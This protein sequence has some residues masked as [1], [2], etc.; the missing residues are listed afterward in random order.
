MDLRLVHT[1]VGLTLRSFGI[2]ILHHGQ[3]RRHILFLIH[4]SI[5]L[6]NVPGLVRSA[7]ADVA[8]PGL[9]TFVILQIINAAVA[10][11]NVV[12]FLERQGRGLCKGSFSALL[13]ILLEGLKQT[14]FCPSLCHV[15]S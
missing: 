14:F 12:V 2:C 11:V 1:E 3:G 13:Q 4:R 5:R 6:G 7:E 15:S 8:E 10:D 9:V